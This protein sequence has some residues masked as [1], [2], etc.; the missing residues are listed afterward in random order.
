M[1]KSEYLKEM[2]FERYLENAKNDSEFW[3]ETIR[4]AKLKGIGPE[5]QIRNMWKVIHKN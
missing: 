5:E 2:T 1:E 3:A 4:I